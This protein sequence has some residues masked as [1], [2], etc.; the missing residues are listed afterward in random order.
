MTRPR[1]QLSR[2]SMIKGAGTVAVALP[3]LEAMVR[4]PSAQ[5]AAPIAG[6]KRF[7]AVYTPGG[8]VPEKWRPSGTSETSFGLSPILAPLE[9]VKQRII[10]VDGLH[11]KCGD[12]SLFNVEQYQGGMVGWLTGMVQQGA[13]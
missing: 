4:R 10:V 13:R 6:P 1:L 11:L 2:R 9:P 8:T 5:A 7:L 3:W 12:Q